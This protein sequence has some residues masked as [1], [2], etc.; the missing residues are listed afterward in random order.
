MRSLKSE[1]SEFGESEV[2]IKEG[3]VRCLKVTN[4]EKDKRK[5]VFES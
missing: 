5:E 1:K 4:V 2:A 3:V